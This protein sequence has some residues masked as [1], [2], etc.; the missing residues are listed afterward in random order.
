MKI[1]DTH[2]HLG[3]CLIFGLSIRDEDLVNY[4]KTHDVRIIVQ[5]FPGAPDPVKVHDRIHELSVR[6][7]GRVYGLASINPFLN[8]E[9]VSK[10][11]ER[12]LGELKFKGVK[13]HTAGHSISPPNPRASIIFEAARKHKVP[14][15]IHTGPGPFSDPMLVAPRAEEYPDVKIILAHAGFGIYANAALWLAKKYDNIYLETSWSHTFDL[16]AFLSSVPD[17][18][19]FGTDLVENIP[20]E[21][22]KLQGLKLSDDVKEKFL[23][24]N[25]KTL[26]NIPE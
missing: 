9:L 14:V 1:I 15:M 4:L 23:Y 6:F 5:P 26:F 24:S 7:K 20:V 25:A 18:V 17:K 22:A 11:L 8:S 12:S 13:L 2:M 21:Y 10:E 19:V 16:Q 3:D